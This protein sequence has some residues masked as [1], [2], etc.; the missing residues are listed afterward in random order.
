MSVSSCSLLSIWHSMSHLWAIF[1]L[2][3]L[4]FPIFLGHTLLANF[5][6]IASKI[7]VVRHSFTLYGP[8][9]LISVSIS[10][11]IN[12]LPLLEYGTVILQQGTSRIF[13]IFA[14]GT[15]IWLLHDY[16]FEHL[17]VVLIQ[18]SSCQKCILLLTACLRHMHLIEHSRE[19]KCRKV[20]WTPVTICL[21]YYSVPCTFVLP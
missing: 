11:S 9:V 18:H 19:V 5:Q 12:T 4:Y 6:N 8:P 15:A 14:P 20:F 17:M 16:I 21:Y 13:L 3:A 2:L 1:V 10:F 7:L